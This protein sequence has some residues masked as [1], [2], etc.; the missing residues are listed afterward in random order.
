MEGLG[1]P[2]HPWR[3]GPSM[4]G[5]LPSPQCKDRVSS[6]A[7]FHRVMGRG[8]H[9]LPQAKAGQGVQIIHAGKVRWHR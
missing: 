9:H 7:P 6:L 4:A 2:S 1:P 3:L 5:S 8:Q